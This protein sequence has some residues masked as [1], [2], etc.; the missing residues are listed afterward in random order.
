M[1]QTT[2]ALEER[3]SAIKRSRPDIVWYPY[4]S[5]ANIEHLAMLLPDLDILGSQA[6]RSVLD[7]GAA[8]G[9]LAFYLESLGARVHAID[10]AATNMNG[11]L[12]FRALVDALGS[13]VTFADVDLDSQ[14]QLTGY[15][16][17]AVFLG[18]LYH[19]KNPFYVLEELSRHA[20]ACV[21]STRVARFVDNAMPLGGCSAYLLDA[22]ECN[23][24]ATN[25]WVF[26]EA[27]LRRLLHRT[28]WDVQ[29]LLTIGDEALSNPR[30]ADHDERAFVYATS[31][32][33][34]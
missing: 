19:L 22:D 20:R 21:L 8:D 27:G 24:D 15:S 29:A 7:L 17:L 34:Q 33:V 3:L 11:T 16:D 26:N 14:F 13:R 32:H 9:D 18:L 10:H 6:D 30:D 23:G 1:Y 12:G 2:Q 28:G 25:F 4:H 5:L 31:R